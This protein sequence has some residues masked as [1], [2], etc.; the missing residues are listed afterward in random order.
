MDKKQ[1]IGYLE[2]IDRHLNKKTE[3]CVFGSAAFIL[4]DEVGRTSQDIDVAA[5][6][7]KADYSDLRQAAE[8]S[9]L[10]LNPD[11]TESGDHIEWIQAGR[12][13]LP[14][15]S[16]RTQLVLWQGAKLTVK[17]VSPA[18][19]IASKL[20]RYDEIDQ[21]DILFLFR[22]MKVKWS[23]IQEAIRELPVPFRYDPLVRENFENLKVDLKLW[24]KR[25]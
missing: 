25:P 5:P 7:S 8:K 13:C 14:E 16:S 17:T 19:L 21:G 4:L 20:I 6:Y 24:Q 12:L 3:L 9:G 11:A 1:L 2:S 23:E 10:K 18:Q 15:P 22:L